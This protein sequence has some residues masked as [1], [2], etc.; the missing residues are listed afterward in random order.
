MRTVP[1]TPLFLAIGNGEIDFTE[2]LTLMTSTERY[3]ETLRGE[4]V[5]RCFR[6]ASSRLYFYII[7]V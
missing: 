4:E 3:L 5:L 1:H 7:R 6:G 2:F